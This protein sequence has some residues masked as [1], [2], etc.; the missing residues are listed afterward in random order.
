[1]APNPTDLRALRAGT[2]SQPSS[3]ARAV[4]GAGAIPEPRSRWVTRLVLPGVILLA[5]AGTIAYAARDALRPKLEV[6][7]APVVPKPRAASSP[8]ADPSATSDPG[9]RSNGL[10]P[11]LVQAPGWVEPDP[12]AIT[13]PALAEGVVREVLVLEGDT[14]TQGQVVARLVDDE[15]RLSASIAE[16]AVRGREADADRA[17]TVIATADAQVRVEEASAEELR[18]EVTRKRDLVAAGGISE[19]AFRRLEI[20]LTGQEAKVAGAKLAADEARASLR[21]ALSSLEGAR[22]AS[23]EA[24]LRLERME[25][26]S[27][28]AGVVLTRLVEPGS[29][30][31]MGGNGAEFGAMAGAVL[32]VYDPARLQVRVDV[33]LADAAKVG[34]GSHATITSEALPDHTFTGV[35]SRVVHEAN[36]Q[37]N[38]VQF[39]VALESP[40]PV[41][42]PEMLTRVKLHAPASGGE[43]GE[44]PGADSPAEGGGQV[45]LI[46]AAG[47]TKGEAG[48]GHVWI[49]DSSSGAPL[50]RRAEIRCEDSGDPDYVV[51]IEGIRLTDRVV[52]DPPA[53][54]REGARLRVLHDRATPPAPTPP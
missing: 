6:H 13:V 10:G 43:G 28:V 7:V 12:F 52:V 27:P 24:A 35:V 33:P 25:V 50:A 42:K 36:I 47:V 45:L 46:P 5:A 17:R 41:L 38:T 11:V 15:A 31:S 14:V 19:G 37:R 18:D 3:P 4:H 44:V 53:N 32:R 51:V 8:G 1:M 16:E 21:Q 48:R 40:T 22:L 9:A 54:I 49:V 23:Q 34:I 39:K 26:R 20:R 2:S 30:I 29:R